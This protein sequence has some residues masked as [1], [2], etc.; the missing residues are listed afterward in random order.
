MSSFK[1]AEVSRISL[2]IPLSNYAWY[3][4]SVIQNDNDGFCVVIHLNYI[5]NNVRK[6]VPRVHQGVLVKLEVD[7]K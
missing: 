5:D 3:K 7:N 6:I 4:N 2:K 1:E